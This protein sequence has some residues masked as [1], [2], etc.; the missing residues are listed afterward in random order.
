MTTIEE[1][2]R[3]LKEFEDDIN[4]K[5]RR[6][7]I[8]ERQKIIG[9]TASEASTNLFAILLHK[10]ELIVPGFNVN[11]KFFASVRRASEKFP[12]DFP[13]KEKII[14]LLVKQEDFRDK[15][16][17]GRSKSPEL[18]KDAIKNYFMLKVIVEKELGE[19]NE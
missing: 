14:E 1:H 10:K 3:I 17:Y 7:I 4:E 13:S 9:F 8:V 15:I 6:E 18:I 11:H 5:I 12:Y 19:N 16:C 2:K